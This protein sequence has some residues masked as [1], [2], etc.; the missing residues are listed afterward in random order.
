MSRIDEA[1]RRATAVTE[2]ADARNEEPATGQ[3]Y[4]GITN[5][6]VAN[7]GRAIRTLTTEMS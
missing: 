2:R 3:A 1:L 7:D 4:Q 6:G 5:S